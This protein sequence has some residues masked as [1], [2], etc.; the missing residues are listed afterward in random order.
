[1]EWVDLRWTYS[2]M[3]NIAAI[4]N[5]QEHIMKIADILIAKGKVRKMDAMRIM[6]TEIQ[7]TT[8]RCMQIFRMQTR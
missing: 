1:M 7:R 5:I 2:D 3:K 8:T 4:Q 6:N